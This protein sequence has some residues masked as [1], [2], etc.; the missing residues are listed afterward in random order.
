MGRKIW[1]PLRVAV[2]PM[3]LGPHHPVEATTI[4]WWHNMARVTR[5]RARLLSSE[6]LLEGLKLGK[7]CEIPIPLWML[8]DAHGHGPRDIREALVAG[9]CRPAQQARL[10]AHG[11]PQLLRSR[12][13]NQ[14]RKQAGICQHTLIHGPFDHLMT[15]LAI[16][17][18]V[19]VLARRHATTE[20]LAVQVCLEILDARGCTEIFWVPLRMLLDADILGPQ[21]GSIALLSLER[22]A[23]PELLATGSRPQGLPLRLFGAQ[24]QQQMLSG[25]AIGGATGH[26]GGRRGSRGSEGGGGGSNEHGQQR[27]PHRQH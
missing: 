24:L 27:A 16:S 15:H 26:C 19:A 17:G 10:R 9:S 13:R 5:P 12:T 14:P 8:M 18:R 3:L 20:V 21:D 4:S 11:L 23:A 7:L 6:I 1:V 2:D 25:A 22:A